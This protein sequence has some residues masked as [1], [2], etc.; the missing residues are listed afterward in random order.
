MSFYYQSKTQD[1]KYSHIQDPIS[2]NVRVSTKRD[3]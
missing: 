2:I 3:Y 1:T